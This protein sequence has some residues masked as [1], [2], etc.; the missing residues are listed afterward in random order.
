MKKLGMTFVKQ[1]VYDDGLGE[2]ELVFYSCEV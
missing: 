2:E 1:E